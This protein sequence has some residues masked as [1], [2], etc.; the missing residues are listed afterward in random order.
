MLSEYSPVLRNVERGPV[1]KLS[2]RSASFATGK[3]LKNFSGR[4]AGR[5]IWSVPIGVQRGLRGAEWSAS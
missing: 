5:K 3:R 2:R 4:L 1:I